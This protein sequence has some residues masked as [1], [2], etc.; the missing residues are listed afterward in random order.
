MATFDTTRIQQ[1]APG[2]TY[3]T[4]KAMPGKFS[5]LGGVLDV[6]NTAIK[7]AVA[8]DESLT[9]SDAEQQ[10]E[11][12]RKDYELQ[13]ASN[14]NT[15]EQKKIFLE[16]SL[17]SADEAN[18]D[19]LPFEEEL[20]EVTNKLVLAKNQGVMTPYE[21]QSRASIIGE[22]MIE[23]NPAYA[24]KITAKMANV[25]QRGNLATLLKSDVA[26]IEAA[27]A[28]QAAIFK[29]KTDYLTTRKIPWQFMEADEIDIAFLQEQK[30][31]RDALEIKAAVDANIRLDENQ[32]IDFLNNIKKD[33]PGT[34]IY[35]AAETQ[36]NTLF[37]QL[38][39]L[40]DSNVSADEK[41]DQR[42]Q[43]VAGARSYLDWFVGNLP[44]RTEE[45]KAANTRFYTN[46]KELINDLNTE[47]KSVI[48][49]NEKD[50]LQQKA[51]TIRLNQELVELE[52]GWNQAKA[53]NIKTT[54]EAWKLLRES[55]IDVTSKV[56]P[57]EIL[58]IKDGL[59][60]IVLNEGGKLPPST[61]ANRWKDL[62]HYSAIKNFDGLA[63]AELK[64]GEMQVQT[65]GWFNNIFQKVDSLTGNNKLKEQDQLLPLLT[66][67]ISNPVF[68]TLMQDPDFSASILNNLEFYKEAIIN[69][70]PDGLEL[71]MSNGLFYYPND[72]RINKNVIRLN[73]Y[74]L[75][76]AKT[77]NKT[78]S[79]ISEDILNNEFPMFNI[80]GQAPKQAATT[81]EVEPIRVTTEEEV[82]KLAPGTVF[83]G[84]KGIKRVR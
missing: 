76:K 4:P 68:N 13:S 32:K 77:E 67:K 82:L 81:Q 29:S 84:P 52:N 8:L 40:E 58:Q 30:S 31:E 36:W 71:T 51:D 12:L 7:G 47:M 28:Q 56:T 44:S 14:I 65:K 35:G 9:L 53:S 10:A 61:L 17:A 74:I 46:Q 37:N 33:H 60:A 20:N 15:L 21:F 25:F 54:L 80:K 41:N 55:G 83:I 57:T 24:D 64:D 48:P 11:D 34:G 66:S 69:T 23:K 39:L 78:P 75:M 1:N 73:N 5:K 59:K 43:L 27:Q 63:Q 18:V 49:G 45:E 3:A 2:L 50:F 42:Q 79:Q 72:T 16:Q 26:A 38:E 22:E 6:A 19:P 70:I 62:N